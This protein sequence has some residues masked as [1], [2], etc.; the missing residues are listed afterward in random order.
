MATDSTIDVV[1]VY[2]EL[3]GT[4]GDRGNAAALVHRARARD[5]PCRVVEVGVHDPLPTQGDIYLIGGGEDAAMVLAWDQLQRDDGLATAL[6]G[7]AACFGVCAGYQLLAHDFT[8][9]D[10][11]RREGL[12]L[13]DVRCGRLAPARA[14]GEVLAESLDEL[15]LGFLTGFENHQGD[16]VLGPAARPLGRLVRGIGNGDSATEGAVQG[17]VIGTYLHGPALVRND[18]LADHLLQFVTGPLDPIVDEPVSRLRAERRAA[19]L[20]GREPRRASAHG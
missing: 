20:A 14:V 19:A 10:G 6:D 2:P 16:A 13:L 18:G 5:L 12:G 9:P 8:G 11:S 1:L 17:R 15:D 3:L 7:G 4:Y